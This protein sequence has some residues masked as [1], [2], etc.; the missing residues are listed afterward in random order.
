[1]LSRG[2]GAGRPTAP[3]GRGDAGSLVTGTLTSPRP[4]LISSGGLPP[5]IR[6]FCSSWSSGASGVRVVAPVRTE[7]TSVLTGRGRATRIDVSI[8]PFKSPYAGS[9]GGVW[10]TSGAFVRMLLATACDAT[11]YRP[12]FRPNSL[13]G[14]VITPVGGTCSSG[15]RLALPGSGVLTGPP[16]GVGFAVGFPATG[17]PP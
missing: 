17:P 10:F 7:S 8:F 12:V 15:G 16:P 4:V 14:T 13:V 9:I 6:D 11:L 2:A 5:L 1:M 3:V